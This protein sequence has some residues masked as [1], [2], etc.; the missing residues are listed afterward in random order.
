MTFEDYFQSHDIKSIYLLTVGGPQEIFHDTETECEEDWCDLDQLL[1]ESQF[2]D[3]FDLSGHVEN[4]R[5]EWDGNGAPYWYG[6]LRNV[7]VQG[8]RNK[9]K[10]DDK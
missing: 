5:W 9:G 7:I 8:T 4:G 10:S 6:S 3:L 2:K 1:R